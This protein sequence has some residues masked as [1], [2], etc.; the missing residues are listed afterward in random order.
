MFSLLLEPVKALLLAALVFV[1]FERLAGERSAQPVFR[2][3]W[4]ID[5]ITAILNGL[6]IYIV[7][8]L[9]LGRVDAA[10]AHAAP[11]LRS[12]VSNCPLWAQV[13]IALVVG[14]LGIYS[15]H[16]LAHTVPWL[17]RLHAVHHSAEE[18]DWLVAVRNHPFDLLL[19]RL[20]SMT[21]I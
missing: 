21:S 14:D 16:R 7:L 8:I 5:A 3:G 11:H 1:P 17:W 2:R 18:M 20:A 9:V 12:W 15:I 6:L 13:V 4:A 19:F 10:A